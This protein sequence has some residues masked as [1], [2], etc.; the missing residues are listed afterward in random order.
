MPVLWSLEPIVRDTAG[1]VEVPVCFLVGSAK[2]YRGGTEY[3][4]LAEGWAAQ[5]QAVELEATLHF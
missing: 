2:S 4:G 1:K 5:R 3:L